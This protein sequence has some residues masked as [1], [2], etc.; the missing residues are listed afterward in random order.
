MQRLFLLENKIIQMQIIDGNTEFFI[1]PTKKIAIHDCQQ[2][3]I[4]T[5]ISS[6][7][8]NL[9]KRGCVK[10]SSFSLFNNQI[11]IRGY[12]WVAKEIQ[13][14]LIGVNID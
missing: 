4:D 13:D 12:T 9:F 8:L 5:I 1:L 11:E 14:I 3:E 7:L 10:S 6:T 2:K